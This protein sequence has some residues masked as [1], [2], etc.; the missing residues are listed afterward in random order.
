[1]RS[2]A[3]QELQQLRP[4]VGEGPRVGRL[5]AAEVEA[6]AVLGL[7]H[8]RGN[9]SGG[10]GAGGPVAGAPREQA[11]VGGRGG[12]RRQPRYDRRGGAG[13][14]PEVIVRAR[15]QQHWSTNTFYRDDGLLIARRRGMAILGELHGRYSLPI[16]RPR[17]VRDTSAWRQAWVD[18]RAG[19]VGSHRV[20]Q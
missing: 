19:R 18:D 16:Q 10:H 8:R 14:G 11:A 13:R 1:Q 4:R 9:W 3:G 2:P 7:D 20:D 12:G 17:R 6:W 5:A 15:D